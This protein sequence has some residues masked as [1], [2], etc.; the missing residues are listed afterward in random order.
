MSCAEN[1]DQIGEYVDGTLAA[2]ERRRLEEHL[3]ACENCRTLA[4]DLGRIRDAAAQ[5]PAVTP[6]ARVWAQIAREIGLTP[7]KPE[8]AAPTPRPARRAAWLPGWLLQPVP[9][10][11]AALVILLAIAGGYV[12]WPRPAPLATDSAG[13]ASPQ[14]LVQ[15]VGNELRMAAAHYENAIAGLEQIAASGE[16]TLDPEVADTLRANLAVIDQAILDSQEALESQPGS[17]LAQETLFEAFR[18]KVGLL[19]DTIALINE[20]RKGNEAG[21]AR[22]VGGFDKS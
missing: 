12:F 15:S 2:D 8:A 10:M 5:L 9:A 22:I 19:Q 16:N 21:A 13:H 18:R 17:Q 14:D 20:M 3:Q 1:L 4:A 7:A 11:M 6:P